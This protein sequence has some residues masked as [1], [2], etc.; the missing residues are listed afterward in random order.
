MQ[1][2]GF[3]FMVL[4]CGSMRGMVLAHPE[5]VLRPW[6][7]FKSFSAR[8]W[9]FLPDTGPVDCEPSVFHSIL[10][11]SNRRACVS[12]IT[13]AVTM[14]CRNNR[15]PSDYQEEIFHAAITGAD[16]FFFFNPTSFVCVTL[17]LVCLSSLHD[18]ARCLTGS[19]ARAHVCSYGVRAVMSDH[20]LLSDCLHEL[21]EVMGC[22]SR[23][24]IKDDNVNVRA[25]PASFFLSGSVLGTSAD[26]EQTAIWR[27]TPRLPPAL[28]GVPRSHTI[29]RT[30]AKTEAGGLTIGPVEH[31]GER[32]S[33]QFDGGAVV[34]SI[35]DP[36][37]TMAPYGL[38]ISQPNANASVVLSCGATSMGWPVPALNRANL[39]S[40]KLG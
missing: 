33:L 23:Q 3:N 37:S 16:R 4:H 26:P 36:S 32:C 38:W 11:A 10:V 34:T 2:D 22:A 18:C 29:V 15:I 27:F 13:E 5:M 24:W 7:A 6:P 28:D 31:D 30:M 35:S 39:A 9:D 12:P 25:S 19:Y 14:H 17:A 1:R 20:K 21:D 40:R 8:V